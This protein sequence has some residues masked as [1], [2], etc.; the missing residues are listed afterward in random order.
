MTKCKCKCNVNARLSGGIMTSHT[1]VLLSLVSPCMS[2]LFCVSC[3]SSVLFSYVSPF[4]SSNYPLSFFLSDRTL[5]FHS[6]YLAIILMWQMFSLNKFVLH[7]LW[8][9]FS[10][11]LPPPSF[12]FSHFFSLLSLSPPLLSRGPEC[13]QPGLCEGGLISLPS[14]AGALP[15]QQ[16]GPLC[17]ALLWGLTGR[18]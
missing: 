12:S 17:A 15:Y 9:C 1:T 3:S 5:L 16:S 2:L 7:F 13:K 11:I 6:V 4:I 8:H 10:V 14:W 18:L